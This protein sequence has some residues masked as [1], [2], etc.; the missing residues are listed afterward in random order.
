M[1]VTSYVN[2]LDVTTVAISN[3]ENQLLL[4]MHYIEISTADVNIT[5]YIIVE[6][7]TVE[8]T[9][10]ES[11]VANVAMQLL[12]SV[13]TVYGCTFSVTLSTSL[14][15]KLKLESKCWSLNIPLRAM[16]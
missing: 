12:W 2:I 9:I 16:R 5:F 1:F 7:I 6:D 11:T 8:T 4:E 14:Y 3:V 15:K 13:Y 10:V